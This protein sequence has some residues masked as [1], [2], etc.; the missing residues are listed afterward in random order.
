MSWNDVI[1]A[2]KAGRYL[3]GRRNRGN[4]VGTIFSRAVMTR[5]AKSGRN[6]RGVN[7]TAVRTC[8]EVNVMICKCMYNTFRLLFF[9]N[10]TDILTNRPTSQFTKI[11]KICPLSQLGLIQD[12]LG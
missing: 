8:H 10:F 11:L 2:V 3:F 6:C 4:K 12:T 1:Q 7:V 5:T 9:N